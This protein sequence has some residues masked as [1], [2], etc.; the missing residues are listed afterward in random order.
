MLDLVHA[1][2]LRLLYEPTRAVRSL[3]ALLHAIDG[4][5]K[6]Y[7]CE[8]LADAPAYSA[9]RAVLAQH[10]MTGA[11]TLRDTP[12]ES[13]KL[14]ASVVMML[15]A[16][17]S[18]GPQSMME[19]SG[20]LAR[21][22]PLCIFRDYGS[23][24]ANQKW[25]VL[26]KAVQAAADTVSRWAS[27]VGG[28][29]ARA[30]CVGVSL[31]DLHVFKQPCRT[32]FAHCFALVL[33]PT[34]AAGSKPAT[35]AAR[36]FQAYGPLDVG[37]SLRD[38]VYYDTGSK[39]MSEADVHEFV[40]KHEAFE[41]ST[42]W[43]QAEQLYKEMFAAVPNGLDASWPMQMRTSVRTTECTRASVHSVLEMMA[44]LLEL[45]Y[46]SMVTSD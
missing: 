35:Y 13:C 16:D 3:Q 14:A 4:R 9:L 19:G 40:R 18:Q 42:N 41:N 6:A 27:E 23:R 34:P 7:S 11:G 22:P 43:R 15:C 5:G 25:H 36:I 12:L 29:R 24:P 10:P 28:G 30:V 2:L 39:R 17:L 37:Y 8:D 44:T 46:A 1:A 20:W 38:A 33:A 31:G 21:S 26:S 32:G 45:P